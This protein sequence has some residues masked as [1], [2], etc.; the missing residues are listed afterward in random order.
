MSALMTAL[1]SVAFLLAME[2]GWSNEIEDRLLALL[3]TE[4]VAVEKLIIAAIRGLF[5]A[6]IMYPA[7]A[8]VLGR[9]P[10][11][12]AGL[13][14]L[15]ASI[16]LGCWA[17]AGIGLTI[18]T[19][20]PPAKIGIMFGLVLTPLM[21]TGATQYPWLQLDRLRWFQIVTAANPLDVLCRGRPR[22]DGTGRAAHRPVDLRRRALVRRRDVHRHR[23][24]ELPQTRLLLTVWTAP[25]AESR[26]APIRRICAQCQTPS[27][28]WEPARNRR[29]ARSNYSLLSHKRFVIVGLADSDDHRPSG[30]VPVSRPSA[31]QTSDLHVART[32]KE[33]RIQVQ[34]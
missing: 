8:L 10:W 3:P 24:M 1:Q 32:Q 17:G 6:V 23:H 9:A 33:Q 13:G 5:A 18:G 20:V 21:F 2:F 30:E 27:S 11:H 31:A 15:V 12:P 16:L 19:L 14:L 22:G 4:L 34:K 25:H 7:G 28:A 26:S 29:S